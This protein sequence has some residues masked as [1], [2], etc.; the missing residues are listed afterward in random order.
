ME[1]QKGSF[2]ALSPCGTEQSTEG[3]CGAERQQTVSGTDFWIGSTV[4]MAYIFH[5]F[6]S[7]I[8]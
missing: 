6:W 5:I 2:H 1:S 7:K 3:Q 8:F 4:F